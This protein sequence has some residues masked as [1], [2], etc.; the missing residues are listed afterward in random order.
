MNNQL[1]PVSLTADGAD[2]S[3]PGTYGDG[4]TFDAEE[5]ALLLSGL[6]NRLD[7]LVMSKPERDAL[8]LVQEVCLENREVVPPTPSQFCDVCGQSLT[9]G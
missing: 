2:D 1:E 6:V 9:Q 5:R 4:F 7:L 8:K 3:R